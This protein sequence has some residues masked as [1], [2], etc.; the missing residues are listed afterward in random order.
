MI[1]VH[2]HILTDIL[3]PMREQACENSLPFFTSLFLG[4]ISP[5]VTL[6]FA[7]F[8]ADRFDT[9]AEGFNQIIA[10]AGL[11]HAVRKRQIEFYAGR[12]LARCA[13]GIHKLPRGATGAPVWP[14]GRTGAISHIAQSVALIEGVRNRRLGVDVQEILHGTELQAVSS[15]AL[16]ANE[17]TWLE[18]EPLL[19]QTEL[20]TIAFS[21]KEAVFKALAAEID[22]RPD[23]CVAE[24]LPLTGRLNTLR[25]KLVTPLADHLPIGTILKAY[26]G[27]FEDEVITWIDETRPTCLL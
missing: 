25:L 26:F 23:F 10:Q 8:D 3:V 13:I 11:S 19:R 20:I 24:M 14:V 6:C 9:T 2:Q 27:W 21:A 1:E 4:S 16:N 7:Q 15:L 18:G 5:D 22:G 12:C 17:R